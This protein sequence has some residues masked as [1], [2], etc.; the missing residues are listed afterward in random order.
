MDDNKI[1]TKSRNLSILEYIRVLEIEWWVCNFRRKI[2]P[3][4]KDKQHFTKVSH[5][6]RLRII[7]MSERN[8]LPHIFDDNEMMKNLNKSL[9]SKGG[10]PDFPDKNEVD[11][12]F[13]YLKDS[14]IR[15]FYGFDGIGK[16]IIKIGKIV[17]FDIVCNKVEISLESGDCEIL[18][19]E[20]VTR[21]F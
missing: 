14:E 18:A 3:N 4:P 5:L 1:A 8:E 19:I 21:I 9:S 6:K 12:Y 17:S 15:A 2:Y 11:V 16:P 10:C 7:E 20:H 13:Y